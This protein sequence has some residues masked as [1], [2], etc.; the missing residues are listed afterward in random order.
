MTTNPGNIFT[1][2]QRHALLIVVLVLLSALVLFG[3]A[4]YVSAFLGAGILYVT[5]RPWH[6]ALAHGRGWNR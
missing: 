5:L 3:L 2:R 4:G 1:P 6:R